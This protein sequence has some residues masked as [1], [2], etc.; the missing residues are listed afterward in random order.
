VLREYAEKFTAAANVAFE[1]PT[2]TG[3][4]TVGMLI[5]EP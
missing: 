1:L 2:G 5:A 4:T 3:K